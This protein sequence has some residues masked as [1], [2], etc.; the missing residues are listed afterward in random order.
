LVDGEVRDVDSNPASPEAFGRLD[1]GAAAAERVEHKVPLVAARRDNAL[2]ESHRL[3]R[4]IAE[5]LFRP[6]VQAD[7]R[8]DV[9]QRHAGLLV[10][11]P[12]I[13][14]HPG[15]PELDPA[16]QEHLIHLLP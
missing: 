10:Q 13:D 16:I 11:V 1:G 2:Q 6:R 3:L 14:G 15:A 9:L 12:L 7:V 8:P 5:P 4:R